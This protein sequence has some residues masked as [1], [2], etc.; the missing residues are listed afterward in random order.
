[1]RTLLLRVPTMVAAPFIALAMLVGGLLA[2]VGYALMIA[3]G[4]V[5]AFSFLATAFNLVG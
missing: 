2:L 4:A 1:M 5:M 3:L